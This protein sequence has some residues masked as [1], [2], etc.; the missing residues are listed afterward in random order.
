MNIY[1]PSTNESTNQS[2]DGSSGE[3]DESGQSEDDEDSTE[4]STA[5]GVFSQQVRTAVDFL[6]WRSDGGYTDAN[7][8]YY[9]SIDSAVAFYLFT[10]RESRRLRRA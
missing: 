10:R 6:E 3:G 9:T 1:D 8:D 7:N 4:R 5:F 2:T